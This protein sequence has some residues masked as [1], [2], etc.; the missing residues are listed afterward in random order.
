MFARDNNFHPRIEDTLG[1]K[2]VV[3]W[4]GAL[5]VEVTQ[6][7]DLSVLSP[8][9]LRGYDLFMP[10]SM[11]QWQVEDPSPAEAEAIASFVH[12]GGALFAQ[13]GATVVPK[14]EPYAAYLDLLGTR[15]KGHPEY[16]D[17]QVRIAQP[18]HLITRGLEDFRVSDELYTHAPLA[19]DAQALVTAAW[20]GVAH[21]MA[22][23]RRAGKG[24][25]YYL[26]LGH[27]AA[28]WDHPAF[29]QLVVNGM[30]WLL[31]QIRRPE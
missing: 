7:H 18:D 19:P 28:A 3:P 25:V 13:H 31:D 27:D 4:L 17:F 9:G 12:S 26:A 21:P 11:L 1:P 8:G 30:R 15:F 22:Y 20:E 16:Q 6:T 24:A 5:D 2:Y 29:K 14:P 23:V 10:W